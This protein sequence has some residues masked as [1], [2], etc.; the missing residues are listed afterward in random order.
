MTAM[1]LQ[2]WLRRQI[3]FLGSGRLAVVLLAVLL[4]L[5]ALYLFLPQPDQGEEA[6][7]RWVERTGWLGA[8]CRALGLTDIRHSWLLYAAYGLLFVNLSICM[9]RRSRVA[10]R[11]CRLPDYPPAVSGFSLHHQIIAAGLEP[12]HVRKFLVKRGYRSLVDG[13]AVY[14]LR[15]RF[16]VLGHWLFHMSLLALMAVGAFVALSP[17]P[18]RGTIGIGEGESFDMGSAHFLTSSAPGV[19]DLP[20]L[21]FRVDAVHVSTEGADVRHFDT[22]LTLPDGDQLNTGIN[23]PYRQAPYQVMAHGFGYMPGWVIV[24][25][26]GRML[27]GAWVKLVPFPLDQWDSFDIGGDGNTVYVR[28]HPDGPR[29]DD[30]NGNGSQSRHDP[31]FEAR[32]LWKGE[33]LH[34]GMLAPGER[35][36]LGDGTEFFFLPEI[37]R[38]AMLDI[39]Q[40]RGHALVFACLA[41]MILGLVIRYARIRKEIL[42]QVGGGSPHVLQVY[43]RSE[44]LADL[45]AE[46][47]ERLAGELANPRLDPVDQEG[48]ACTR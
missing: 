6:L 36:L 9:I 41:S 4:I 37:R 17:D 42:V 43:G 28:F 22:L 18:F 39:M 45:F 46:E 38:Y 1:R 14:G 11:A 15:G 34:E 19:A 10:L 26:R 8:S 30:R 31:M 44:I 13:Q 25:P 29:D 2:R 20:D 32:I 23:R 5:V 7:L 27:R 47:L 24:N 48:L 35:V 12:A 40:E 21:S 16:A 33:R 3:D